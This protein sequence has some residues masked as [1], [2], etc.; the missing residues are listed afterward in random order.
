M[1]QFWLRPDTRYKVVAY[2]SET[3]MANLIRETVKRPDEVRSLLRGIYSSEADL[4][5]DHEQ[6]TL[7]V[8]LHQTQHSILVVG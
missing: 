4:S 1:N 3:E 5:P 6:G 7:T 2:R 8:Q